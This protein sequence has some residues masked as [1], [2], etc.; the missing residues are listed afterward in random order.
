MGWASA[1]HGSVSEFL[2]VAFL[3]FPVLLKKKME[4]CFSATGSLGLTARQYAP[5]QVFFR[6]YIVLDR[7]AAISSCC[8]SSANASRINPSGS[9]FESE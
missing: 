3:F 9:R 8:F 4:W 7:H 5:A 6:G 2:R 1:P